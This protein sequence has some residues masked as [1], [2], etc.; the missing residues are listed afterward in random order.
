M[1]RANLAEMRHHHFW[2]LNLTDMSTK[3]AG[4]KILK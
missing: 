4:H 2:L 3:A 1:F